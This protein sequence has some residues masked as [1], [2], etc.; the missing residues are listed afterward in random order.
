MI[1]QKWQKQIRLLQQKKHR[2]E[3]GAFLVEGGKSV[4]ELL[5]ADFTIQA[6]FLTD[7]FYKENQKL[8]D[9]QP[10]SF[11]LVEESELE[12]V[13]TLQS[14]NAALAIART[15]EN[16]PLRVEG[17]EFALILDDI[18][19]PGNLG[20]IIRIADWYGIKKV[21]CSETCVDVYNPK[22]ISATMGSFTRVQTYYVSLQ[23]FLEQEQTKAIYGTFLGGESIYDL[24]FA[25]SGYI[26]IGNEANGIRPENEKFVSKKIT[27]PRFG[28]AESLNAGIAT[29]IVLD[30]WRRG[31]KH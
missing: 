20:T 10:F 27:I 4:L 5:K 25:D 19:D 6:L 18:R 16:R 7:T 23:S 15:K 28:E 14:N 13:G 29:A 24:T 12:K 2:Q 21:I 3:L 8:L 17:S 31:V 26:V 30:N 9:E 11:E 22:V 1:S